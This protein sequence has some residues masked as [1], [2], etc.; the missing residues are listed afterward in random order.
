MP[1][2]EMAMKESP[3]LRSLCA[4]TLEMLIPRRCAA[5]R[6]FY[7]KPREAKPQKGSTPEQADDG[8]LLTAFLCPR[9][10]RDFR[11][12]E[13]PLCTCCGAPFASSEGADHLCG[14][15]LNQ[16]PAFSCARSAGYYEGGL[17]VMI[18]QLKYKGYVQAAAPLS[19]LLWRTFKRHWDPGSIDLLLPVPLHRKRLHGRGFNQAVQL[20]RRWPALAREEGVALGMDRVKP[21][22]LVRRRNT[23]PQTG[24]DSRQRIDNVKGAFMVEST[25]E[26]RKRSILIVDDVFTTGAT[27]DACARTLIKAGASRVCV[28]TL[29]RSV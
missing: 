22:L 24:L 26:V 9:C 2:L 16:P 17:R 29:A 4:T 7:R 1:D 5:C 13:S 14:R 11:A 28:L 3:L 15:C 12:V 21:K 23:P 18:H 8:H 25:S 6:G 10:A 20:L 19:R 27:V